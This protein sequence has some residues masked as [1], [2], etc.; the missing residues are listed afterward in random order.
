MSPLLTAYGLTV[1][2]SKKEKKKKKEFYS[3]LVLNRVDY[4]EAMM[5]IDE[6]I[7]LARTSKAGDGVALIRR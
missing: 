6:R 1:S 3:D 2:Y 5:M 4:K 7:S